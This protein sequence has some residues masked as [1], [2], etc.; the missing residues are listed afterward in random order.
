MDKYVYWR[1]Q[2]K[3]CASRRNC[4]YRERTEDFIHKLSELERSHIGAYGTLSFNC[5]Y[6]N[7]DP[8]TLDVTGH[9]CGG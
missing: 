9:T 1:E 7:V 4:P 3:S 8:T 5:D 2:C 6:F